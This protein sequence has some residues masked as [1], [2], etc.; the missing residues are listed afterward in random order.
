MNIYSLGFLFG[1]AF[2]LS[3]GFF[4]YRKNRRSIT[5]ITWLLLCISVSIWQFG[6]FYMS[7][8]ETAEGALQWCRILYVGA[9]FVPI[10]SIHFIL[11]F[12]NKLE[13]RKAILV[14]AYVTGF[15][16]LILSFTPYFITGVEVRT[17]LGFYEIPGKIYIAH[18]LAFMGAALLIIYDLFSE[19]LST[20]MAIRKNQIKFLFIASFFGYLSGLTSF[21]PLVW[22]NIPLVASPFTA[23]YVFIVSYAIIKYSLLDITVVIKRSIIYSIIILILVV[24]CY[25]IVIW[26]QKIV[27]GEVSLPFSFIVLALFMLV[28][29]IFPRAKV[30]TE[31]T[32]EQILFKREK[33]IEETIHNLSNAMANMLDMAPLINIMV[34]TIVKKLDIECALVLLLDEER[35]EFRI[36]ASCGTSEEPTEKNYEASDFFFQWL[37]R[38]GS[39][40]IK[41]EIME[42]RNEPRSDII[43]QRMNSILAEVL[44]PIISRSK[45]IGVLCLG[46]KASSEIYNENELKLFQTLTNQFAVYVENAKLYENLKESKNLMRRSDRL[47]SLGQLAAGLAHEIRN[48]LVSIK[49]FLQLLPER[50]DDE[51]FRTS[52]LGLTVDEVDRIGRLLSEL[53]DFSKPSKPNFTEENL[54]EIVDKIIMLVV[55]EAKKKHIEIQRNYHDSLKRVFIDKEQIKQVFLNIALNAIQST[56]ENGKIKIETRN[57]SPNGK[58]YV[59]VEVSD[60]GE[61]IPPDDL[62]NIF[63]PF[64]TKKH[65]GSGLGLSISHQII[66]EHMGV[67]KVESEVGV[68]SSFYVNLPVDPLS[69]NRRKYENKQYEEE[70]TD[71]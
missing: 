19:F 17:D 32:L 29:L 67:I 68:G 14:G 18:F 61:G 66:Q 42:N 55:N 8:A 26:T 10:F 37:A 2:T 41:E 43:I 25:I 31:K 40:V 15:I 12:I 16:E 71:N 57:I 6:R 34:E 59:Q 50:I 27:F 38:R 5:N 69:L 48:P 45:M 7:I 70:N 11:A 24:P 4:V 65:G 30:G 56:P 20:Q 36:T 53:L 39:T 54:N 1:T 44:V 3:S 58:T 46:K 28:G 23:I 64:F 21:F 52:F 62:E 51:E 33:S 35:K 9:I 63:N 22:K 60:T 13:K 47:A 49:T